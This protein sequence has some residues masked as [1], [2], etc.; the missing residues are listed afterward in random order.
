MAASLSFFSVVMPI[1]RRPQL[2]QRA[3]VLSLGGPSLLQRHWNIA[4]KVVNTL[5]I[6]NLIPAYLLADQRS[7]IV[8]CGF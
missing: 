8:G 5:W 6:K 3:H 1:H 4:S 7:A 2:L